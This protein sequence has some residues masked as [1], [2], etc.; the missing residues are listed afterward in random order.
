M[1]CKILLTLCL[2]LQVISQ[3]DHDFRIPIPT[4]LDDA[5]LRCFPK[6]ILFDKRT[7]SI[8]V[9]D[10]RC[11]EK[12]AI[13]IPF[14]LETSECVI[15]I[16]PDEKELLTDCE[17]MDAIRKKR[18]VQ[19]ESS[20]FEHRR[21]PS[22]RRVIWPLFSLHIFLFVV[23]GIFSTL[24]FI[25]NCRGFR[26]FESFAF[27]NELRSQRSVRTVV[28]DTI[29][30]SNE[31]FTTK[32]DSPR[33]PT[34]ISPDKIGRLTVTFS[35]DP[36]IPKLSKEKSEI[37]PSTKS[38]AEDKP[39]MSS[40]GDYGEWMRKMRER[41]PEKSQKTQKTEEE[42]ISVSV[43]SN[44]KRRRGRKATLEPECD[45]RSAGSANEGKKGKSVPA[46]GGTLKPGVSFA[47]VARTGAKPGTT[48]VLSAVVPKKEPWL[49]SVCDR[50]V[51]QQAGRAI[52]LKLARSWIGKKFEVTPAS[53]GT[54]TADVA[55]PRVASRDRS[56]LQAKV[57][58]S[59]PSNGLWSV[60]L[61][62][63]VSK[64]SLD[65]QAK[66]QA[67]Q[68]AKKA[69]SWDLRLQRGRFLLQQVENGEKAQKV[70]FPASLLFPQVEERREEPLKPVD[71]KEE[72]SFPTIQSE[73]CRQEAQKTDVRGEK[74]SGG[75]EIDMDE[76]VKALPET[77]KRKSMDKTPV[78]RKRN[79]IED[80]P[81][82]ARSVFQLP[83]R[84][85]D[86]LDAER[87]FPAGGAWQNLL[88]DQLNSLQ[89][90]VWIDGGVLLHYFLLKIA[91][92]NATSMLKTTFVSPFVWLASH[93][94]N[95]ADRRFLNR[96]TFDI[97]VI[98]VNYNRT[99]WAVAVLSVR[100]NEIFYFDSLG[101]QW[102]S[103]ETYSEALS[104]A[105]DLRHLR[106]PEVAEDIRIRAAPSIRQSD[107]HSCGLF[108]IHNAL[109]AVR[110]LIGQE[111][112]VPDVRI[113]GIFNPVARR[114]EIE[115]FLRE[116]YAIPAVE[117]RSREE[118][119]P[120][121]PSSRLC[122]ALDSASL[123]TPPATPS[124]HLR[125]MNLSQMT[126]EEKAE[127][128]RTQQK[129]SRMRHRDEGNERKKER[130]ELNKEAI[131]EKRKKTRSQLNSQRHSQATR[132]CRA[133]SH[134][135]VGCAAAD[136][137]HLSPCHDVGTFDHH[138]EHCK[139]LLLLCE[140]KKGTGLCCADGK[141]DLSSFYQQLQDV[142]PIMRTLF[143]LERGDVT[144]K[145]L[146]MDK[147]LN[148]VFAFACISTQK[149]PPMPGDF[150]PCKINGQITTYFSG[151]F[152]PDGKA[153]EFGQIYTLSSAE[154]LDRHFKKA[155][156][157][158][159]T[160]K[161]SNLAN[162]RELIAI[163]ESVLQ[164]NHPYASLY[165]ST[166]EMYREAEERAKAD[167]TA[168]PEL[169]M[170]VLTN[171]QAK[172]E[173]I[174]DATVH[175]HR[176][177]V[178]EG[179]GH[180]GVI[181]ISATGEPPKITGVVLTSRKGELRTIAG[182]SVNPVLFPG[183]FPL[184]N[185]KGLLGYK[186]GIP[187]AGVV[188]D[189]QDDTADV[190][191]DEENEA[192][193]RFP[194]NGGRPPQKGPRRFV[195]QR[196]FWRYVFFSREKSITDFHWLFSHEQLAEHFVTVTANQIERHEMDYRKQ[197]MDKH[198]LRS[199]LPADLIRGIA[200]RL[201]PGETLGKVYM[202]P[203]F[204]KGSR[205][206]M[207]RAYSNLK[208]ISNAHGRVTFFLT[209][210]GNPYWPEIQESLANKRHK[211]SWIHNPSVVNRV[212][213]AKLDELTKDLT[214]R[215][216][217]GKVAAWGYSV[218][219]QKRGMPH[220]HIL[221]IM[222]KGE[223]DGSVMFVEN[224]I[225]AEIPDRPDDSEAG[226]WAEQQR[227]LHEYV[228]KHNLHDCSPACRVEGKC[229]KRFP[230][231]YSDVTVLEHDKYPIYTRRRPL[232]EGSVITE[233][234]RH[235]FG[236]RFVKCRR[237]VPVVL[238]N[239]NVVPYNAFL[240]LKYNCHINL[241]Y[242]G[243]EK[244]AEY[245]FKYIMKGHDRA[246]IKVKGPRGEPQRDDDGNIIVN[247]DEIEHNFQ[248]RYMTAPEA[249]WRIFGFENVR[250][251]HDVHLLYIYK[252]GGTRII[253]EEG[254]EQEAAR[255]AANQIEENAVTAFFDLCKVDPDARQYCYHEVPLHYT[256][257]KKSGWT[258]RKVK[259]KTI[260]RV[261]PVIAAD[262]I[263]YALRLLLLNKPGPQSYADLR[264]VDG[265]EYPTFM[266]AAQALKLTESDEL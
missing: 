207:Q 85:Q 38:T 144:K 146:R 83:Q 256:Y 57:T 12:L 159:E 252:P 243:A 74:L 151:L 225:S 101:S 186:F 58:V 139:A 79:R 86:L 216:V 47:E 137:G 200:S 136:A 162:C 11:Q 133:K 75:G 60:V 105:Q 199:S 177:S 89:P 202:A 195:S 138:C 241:E 170:T 255:R 3:I 134:S 246:Y 235:R 103:H 145:F 6:K 263:G 52:P 264:T 14:L 232:Q 120:A 215:H 107:S 94:G 266:A 194:N 54:V 26:H 34:P 39:K 185:P 122:S 183:C 97:A 76:E 251:S 23:Y 141:V 114:R 65:L 32:T 48:V 21:K 15:D 250:L 164:E 249:M 77:P 124:S 13:L 239:R 41:F 201:Q 91:E 160:M 53:S 69:R 197:V 73:E 150:Q 182:H 149:A 46:T 67:E 4:P 51:D 230:K 248:V 88:Q 31:K 206:N 108:T 55:A 19:Y 106:R 71:F 87:D 262:R 152:P 176:T 109:E 111:E 205:R 161:D 210:T 40:E 84:W 90:G 217:L 125:R 169:R 95:K 163:L 81:V 25:I 68:V 219:F 212:F 172:L 24:L 240:L 42:L 158:H 222:E 100:R 213:K 37:K 218:E 238:D 208:A 203:E 130:R 102:Q 1:R 221:L 258:K 165:K 140:K 242:V 123:S 259:R 189:S 110:Q 27:G 104:L 121:T 190:P 211:K 184:L 171:R 117:R 135:G 62:S 126:P 93:R 236:N 148:D 78:A 191:D 175:S 142:P 82:D 247:Y 260:V 80:G 193:A 253:Y 188:V 16:N 257:A 209:F 113:N 129:T 174:A 119:A 22:K 66:K 254:Q 227:R 127:H 35:A 30:K 168:V 132:V 179:P 261:A 147:Q 10:N 7:N 50:P 224:Y 167:G 70:K 244:C 166:Y 20:E 231:P 96:D 115:G 128:R 214:E 59:A 36:V 29:E 61:R 56:V 181:W 157:N 192:E 131:N 154:S 116:T 5:L 33:L 43:D 237:G 229:S 265:V 72:S 198:N 2:A 187:L 18:S 112:A 143:D 245:V 9:D 99:H 173:N 118:E 153:P 64:R 44:V 49:I 98:P 156:P 204:W 234:N 178:P 180:V 196:Q 17:P 92:I 45:A 155:F 228:T 233:K 220:A 226:D 28:V 63:N 223:D 8:T